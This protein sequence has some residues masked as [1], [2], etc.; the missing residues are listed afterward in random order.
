MGVTPKKS[1]TS[2]FRGSEIFLSLVVH[3]GAHKNWGSNSRMASG[4]LPPN[5][6]NPKNCGEIFSTSGRQIWTKVQ[7]Y[8]LQ[9]SGRPHLGFGR[10]LT[11]GFR[12]NGGLKIG[13]WGTF[14]VYP[15]LGPA[16]TK[17]PMRRIVLVTLRKMVF[18]W[19]ESAP[20]WGRYGGSKFGIFAKFG[21]LLLGTL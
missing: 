5:P 3:D 10:N 15:L 2:G 8:T 1:P 11:K 6:K 4:V 18:I 7:I 21:L 20:I 17:R 12:K 13:G 19:G 16:P 9:I 14:G